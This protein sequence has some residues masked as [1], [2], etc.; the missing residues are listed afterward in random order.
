M[1]F[2]G[3]NLRDAIYYSNGEP[4]NTLYILKEFPD[5]IKLYLLCFLR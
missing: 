1:Y 3:H 2:F 5:F 4:G